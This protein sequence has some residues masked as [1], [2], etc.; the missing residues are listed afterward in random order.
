MKAKSKKDPVA[1]QKKRISESIQEFIRALKEKRID[2]GA[3][4]HILVD[5]LKE[6]L[7]QDE[8]DKGRKEKTQAQD[9]YE[10]I[11][12]P[13][14]SEIEIFRKR[15]IVADEDVEDENIHIPLSLALEEDSDYVVGEVYYDALSLESLGRTRILALKQRLANEIRNHEKWAIHRRYKPLEGQILVGEILKESPEEFIVMHERNELSIAKSEL[16]PSE[17]EKGVYIPK[18]SGSSFRI[19]RTTK[20]RTYVIKAV[21][22][23]VLSPEEIKTYPRPRGFRGQIPLVFLSRTSQLFL[24][25]LMKAEIP[26]I[27]E[28]LVGIRKIVRAPGLRAKVIVESYDDRIDPV[29]ACVGVKGTRIR[30]IVEELRGEYI[31]VIP[32]TTNQQLLVSR[33]LAPAKVAQVEIFSLSKKAIVYLTPEEHGK[34]IGRDGI[35]VRLAS[36][37]TGYD[38]NVRSISEM[39]EEIEDIELS[40]FVGEVP[41]EILRALQKEGFSYVRQVIALPVEEMHRRTQI[42]L[43]QL[44]QIYRYFEQELLSP[45]DELEET[46]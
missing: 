23:K 43:P 10:I 29:G 46:L 16:I 12:N 35:N 36:E 31:D 19:A 14:T 9:L 11:V 28:G 40:Q 44:Q 42:P 34:A 18:P 24:A 5:A 13:D 1:Q 33:A 45:E 20:A 37:I 3:F 15:I 21:V 22:E 27:A 6:V 30:P 25:A 8:G 38:I 7:L 4:K 41:D 2:E 32:Y 17:R 39:S 26:E